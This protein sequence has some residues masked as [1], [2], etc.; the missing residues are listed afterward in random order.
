MQVQKDFSLKD[1]NTFGIDVRCREMVIVDTESD[2]VEILGMHPVEDLFI[3]GGGSN[4]LFQSDYLDKVVLK[5]TI[6][7]FR[8]IEYRDDHAVVEIGGGEVWHEVVLC[9]IELGLGGI[10]NLSLIPGSTG[11]APIQ[12]IGA[13]GVELK[14]VFHSLTA[15]ELV[16]GKSREMTAD[17]CQFGYRWSVFKGELK[18]KYF[19]TNVRLKLTYEAHVIRD[20]YG[21]IKEKLAAKKIA[22]PS[23]ADL[24]KAICEIRQSKLPDPNKVGNAGS[25][26]KNPIIPL[27][28]FEK[29][30][31][32]HSSIRSYPVD[33]EYVKLPAAWLIEQAG[34]KG[35]DRTN[36]GVSPN[37]ALVLINKGGAVGKDIFKLAMDIQASVN[38]KFGV[39]LEPEVNVVG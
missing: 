11:A 14:D 9:C 35:H 39:M 27:A 26:F 10:E 31:S 8:I 18:G 36:H 16:S 2:L 25:F 23:I 21:A 37:H 4:L 38:E 6:K 15:I 22:Q 12:N 29:L 13:Y 1:H 17:D 32:Q 5:N 34:W 19:I 20:G 7:G 33:D 24:S 30:S 28:Q 3:L